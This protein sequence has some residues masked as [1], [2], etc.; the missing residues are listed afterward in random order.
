MT[1]ISTQSKEL[2]ATIKVLIEAGHIKTFNAVFNTV[3]RTNFAKDMGMN[4]QTLLYRIKHLG[5]FTVAEINAAAHLIG[6][7]KRVIF[8][9]IATEIEHKRQQPTLKQRASSKK[10]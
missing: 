2:Y 10:K 9:L 4:Y 1:T 3:K 8:N 5:S 6:V 7:D